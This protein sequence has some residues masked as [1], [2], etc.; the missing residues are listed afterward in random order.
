MVA[1]PRSIKHSTGQPSSI[2]WGE[3]HE[4]KFLTDMPVTIGGFWVKKGPRR[5]TM[6]YCIL[7]QKKQ[8]TN[9]SSWLDKLK[10]SQET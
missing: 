3:V 6:I 5:S 2:E 9:W 8:S 10:Q 1:C 7:P 4:P